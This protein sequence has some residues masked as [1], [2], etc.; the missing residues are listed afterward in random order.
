MRCAHASVLIKSIQVGGCGNRFRAS[1]PR[2]PLSLPL[3]RRLRLSSSIAPTPRIAHSR[4]AESRNTMAQRRRAG[5]HRR[6]GYRL[7]SCILRSESCSA[8]GLTGSRVERCETWYRW[9]TYLQVQCLPF[10]SSDARGTSRWNVPTGHELPGVDFHL[11]QAS[12]DRDSE[13]HHLIPA[14]NL[15]LSSLFQRATSGPAKPKPP[16]AGQ[17]RA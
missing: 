6:R 12:A 11:G 1:H 9:T 10:R 3:Q 8:I 2:L 17:R 15:R 13:P 14:R 5:S 4:K 16:R 7:G